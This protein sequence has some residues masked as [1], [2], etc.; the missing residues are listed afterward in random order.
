MEEHSVLFQITLSTLWEKMNKKLE[1][2]EHYS[3]IRAEM[4]EFY[5]QFIL[6]LVNKK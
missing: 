2:V 1:C 5:L 6:R 4:S 3:I